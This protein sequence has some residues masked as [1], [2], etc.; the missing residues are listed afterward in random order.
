MYGCEELGDEIFR[1]SVFLPFGNHG[2][3]DAVPSGS[4][5]DGDIMRFL[6]LSDASGNVHSGFKL[7]KQVLIDYIDLRSEILNILVV[8]QIVR[9]LLTDFQ[10]LQKLAKIRWG[11]TLS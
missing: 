5:N 8:V 11:E 3:Q 1:K 4:L 6:E 2:A 9:Y 10:A 7:Q